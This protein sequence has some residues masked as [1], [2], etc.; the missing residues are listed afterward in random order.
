MMGPQRPKDPQLAGWFDQCDELLVDVRELLAPLTDAQVNWRAEAGRWSIGEC[1]DHLTATAGASGH[2][3]GVAVDQARAAGRLGRGPFSYGWL[4]RWFLK[5]LDPAT[6]KKMKIPVES[7]R[8]R[9]GLSC[10][11]VA[12]EFEGGQVNFQRL[13]EA[14]DGL[15]LGRVKARSAASSMLKL[16]LAAWFESTILHERRHILQAKQVLTS[17]GFPQ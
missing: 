9:S 4:G 6:G 13:L 5:Q 12:G 1:I 15:D 17:P 8:P 10:G 14:A 11:R 3:M 16:N 7:F 2:F